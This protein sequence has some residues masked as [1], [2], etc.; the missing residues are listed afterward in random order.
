MNKR[1]ASVLVFA[2]AV[3]AVASLIFYRMI[4]RVVASAA[5]PATAHVLV[6]ARTL[7]LGTLIRDM[8]VKPAEWTGPIPAQAVTTVEDAVN[9]GVIAEIY[10]G[11]PIVATRLA[12]KGAGAGLGAIIPPGMRAVAVRV[13]DV[14]GVQ[15]DDHCVA[16]ID[17][18]A[19]WG[20]LKLP[21]I[22]RDGA[23]GGRA[24][25]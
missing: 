23:R 17:L 20:E 2:V 8:D 21:R 10:E 15:G 1:F 3:A 14:V 25:R 9:R 13:N 12:P 5:K 6:A 18:N 19:G 4:A 24:E 22:Q 11:E 16:L 7:P